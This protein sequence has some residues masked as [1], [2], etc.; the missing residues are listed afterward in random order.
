MKEAKEH[1]VLC[2]GAEFP[3]K[4]AQKAHNVVLLEYNPQSPHINVNI[5]IPKLVNQVFHLPDRIKDL[6]EIAAYVFA[7]D[8][9]TKRGTPDS[10]EYH[11][12][13]RSFHFIIKVRDHQFWKKETVK[14]KLSEVLCFMTGDKACDFTFNS[15]YFT[16]KAGLFD[17][18]NFKIIPS[19]ST[20]VILFSGGLDSLAGILNMLETTND[21]VCLIS[22]VSQNA[23]LRTQKKLYKALNKDYPNRLEPHYTFKCNLKGDTALEET[24]RTRSFLYS[25]IAFAIATAYSQNTFYL[26]ENG[27]TSI[28]FSRREDLIN[29]RASR[30]TH[31]KTLELLTELLSLVNESQIKIEHPFLFK[32]KT[33]ILQLLAKYEKKEYINS[34]VS[35]CKTRMKL[36]NSTHCG[37]CFQCIDRRFAAYGA[38]LEEYDG[39][40]IY[41]VDFIN[42]KI[43]DRAMKTT[44]MDYV[45]LA[46]EFRKMNYM[47]FC[48]ERLAELAD[49]EDYIEGND[50]NEKIEKVYRLCIHYGEQIETAISRMNKPFDVIIPGSFLDI[51]RDR[52]YLKEPVINLAQRISNKLD[53]AIPI[54]FKNNKP[55]NENDFNDKVNAILEGEKDEYK[56]EFP[57]ISFAL[58]KAI[59]DHSI[60]NLDLLIESKYIRGKT[61]PSVASEGIAAD[62][63][64][65]PTESYK[66]FVV[67]DPE[68]QI[69]DKE[70]FKKDFENKGNCT[71]IIIR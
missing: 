1:I 54:A 65:Y 25:S 60:N 13:S 2:N 44:I 8:R 69:A 21:K 28:N 71:V 56:R 61:A 14:N 64:K 37:G 16:G 66:L 34:T 45:R 22:H 12:W 48:S 42:Q 63:T 40:A 68:G 35:C 33:D 3:E 27:I 46:L 53:K 26:F 23:T 9:K 57:S 52:E 32:T 24:Q 31:P 10:M 19:S 41:D 49:L 30:T 51:V 55:K 18:E 43:E 5:P 38:E 39:T 36:Q 47:T 6:L 58:A 15:G 20:S 70:T 62:M 7:A 11:S 67:Y 17:E 4:L 29:A 50:E 59:P